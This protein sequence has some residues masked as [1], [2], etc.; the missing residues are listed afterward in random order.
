MAAF[1]RFIKQF[2]W[3]SLLFS[4]LML[5][6]VM[7]SQILQNAS[8]F[9]EAY[10]VLL[11]ITWLGVGVLLFLF[12]RALWILYQQFKQNIPGIKITIRLT[13]L[14]TLLMGVPAITIFAFSLNFI[15]QG[16][17]QW[18]DVT[19]EEALNKAAN[20]ASVTLDNKT[21][22]SLKLTQ[23][24]VSQ[25]Q[26]GLEFNP[27][28]TV[29]T[30][31]ILLNAQEI[32]LYQTNQ[33]LAAFSAQ[34]NTQILPNSAPGDNL[35]QQVRKE[36]PYAA[37]ETIPG[38][39][40]K[41]QFV[42]VFIPVG[43]S[44]NSQYALQ[45]IFPIP[46]NITEL[47][48]SVSIAAQQYSELS[49]LKGPLTTSFTLILSMVVLLTLVT[50]VLFTV[51]AVQNFT[52]PIRTL[53][54]G[55]KAVSRGDYTIHMPVKQQDEFGELI[56]SF[57]DMIQRIAQAR[58]DIK[59]SHQQAEVQKLYLQAVIQN[60]TSG[61][62]TMD[63]QQQIRTLN[64]A[65]ERILN[66]K[67][68]QL[69]EKSMPSL[70]QAKSLE[71]LSDDEAMQQQSLKLLM[72][73]IVQQ[74]AELDSNKNLSDNSWSMQY[75]F[76]SPN[77]Q[78]ILLLHGSPLPTL[79]KKAAGYIIVIDDITQLVQAQVNAAWSDVARRLA[80]EIK[81]PLTPIQLSAE[82]LNFKL[83]ERL[84]G[85]D[86]DLLNRL[87]QTIIEQVATMQTLVQAFS[88]YANT[89][90]VKL[91]RTELCSLIHG[92]T[93]MYQDPNAA[94][95]V[96]SHIDQNCPLVLADKSRLRQLFH[97]L[98]KNALEACEEIAEPSVELN[99]SVTAEKN[100]EITVCD[101]GP[102]IPREAQNWI[103][104]PYAT[105]KPKGTGLGLAIVRKIVE[106]HHG[107]IRVKTSPMQGTC[108]II[109]L[110][111]LASE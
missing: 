56:I 73:Q 37:I 74:F 110:P 39:T 55:T 82:R 72:A 71:N 38:A 14:A 92:I 90:E 94:W 12:F 106:E 57:N 40:N 36:T 85:D 34:D 70:A 60:L 76:Q 52:S 51:R 77:S 3:V 42:R 79:D 46:Q 11:V 30:I 80:H 43:R 108:F 102:G 59:L 10:S 104:E 64:S 62:I 78:Q 7:M 97:N 96:V 33:Q 65:A 103:F 47:A 22:D 13:V 48:D 19:T 29:D 100:L 86:R 98:I 35:F 9:E 25:Q 75:E 5:M 27:I 41:E 45:A 54:R 53:A 63:T 105:D 88:D 61:V 24:V 99:A 17:N 87:T 23:S 67:S 91:Q 21:R 89:P 8:K 44:L 111:I 84:Q 18:F 109:T 15:Q 66:I 31:R 20:L 16:I 6:L 26:I 95:R 32:A 50:A 69:L 58:N 107:Q 2:G 68:E 49:Y 28:L 93:E 101:N 81:N 83:S 1:G 4:V